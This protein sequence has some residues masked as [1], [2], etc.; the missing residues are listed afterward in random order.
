MNVLLGMD[1][2]DLGFRALEEAVERAREA[3]D[4]LTVAIYGDETARSEAAA[5]VRERLQEAGLE[6]P[7]RHVEGDPGSQLVE[8]ADG[9]GFDRLVVA[10]G[11]RT[12]LGKIRLGSVAEFVLL[13][14]E[15]TVT[16]VR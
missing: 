4:D 15:T 3:G 7:I 11:E 10:G 6:A 13:N 2:S 16:V 12:P 1:G 9:S 14:A 5:R 8:L